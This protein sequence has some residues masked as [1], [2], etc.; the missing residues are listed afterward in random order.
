MGGHLS[1]PIEI[2][3]EIK[4]WHLF[5][6]KILQPLVY[7]K[8]WMKSLFQ[9]LKSSRIWHAEQSEIGLWGVIC[10]NLTRY[11]QKSKIDVICGCK[12]RLDLFLGELEWNLTHKPC[13]VVESD[14]LNNL[15]LAYGGSFVKTWRDIR[16][17]QKL[18][19]FADAKVA[20]TCS[21]ENFNEIWLPNMLIM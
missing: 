3:A 19:S 20:M 13:S 14:M 16:K 21:L 9:P 2:F 11:S 15:R 18:T 17:N 10:Q 1:K 6:S 5:R 4:Y 12:S 7:P 8:T